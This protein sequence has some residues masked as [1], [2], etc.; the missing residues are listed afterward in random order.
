M[1]DGS[2][3]Q[4][5]W[6][7]DVA[8]NASAWLTALVICAWLLHPALSY[9][10]G[11]E[12]LLSLVGSAAAGLV[13]RVEGI[14][15]SLISAAVCVLLWW[16]SQRA[17]RV[18]SKRGTEACAVALVCVCGLFRLVG[19]SA[20]ES[21]GIGIVESLCWL[22]LAVDL[23]P[24]VLPPRDDG[25]SRRF[26]LFWTCALLCCSLM[27]IA[28]PAVF[29][30]TEALLPFLVFTGGLSVWPPSGNRGSCSNLDGMRRM[31]PVSDRMVLVF[32]RLFAIALCAECLAYGR[33]LSRAGELLWADHL[34]LGPASGIVACSAGV[35]VALYAFAWRSLWPVGLTAVAVGALGC[36]IVGPQGAMAIPLLLILVEYCASVVAMART[37]KDAPGV[38]VDAPA[39]IALFATAFWLAHALAVATPAPG[40]L[41][42][43]ELAVSCLTAS[44]FLPLPGVVADN[45]CRRSTSRSEEEILA[46]R[47]ELRLRFGLTEREALAAVGAVRGM[48]T[49]ELARDAC[50][51][52]STMGTYCARAYRK[53]AVSSREEASRLVRETLSCA[54]IT[55]A[56]Q[57]IEA[58]ARGNSLRLP[59]RTLS[60]LLASSAVSLLVCP[61][62]GD[63]G[64][65]VMMFQRYM[66]L[67]VCGLLI[68]GALVQCRSHRR[69]EDCSHTK[70]LGGIPPISWRLRPAVALGLMAGGAGIG[71]LH[72][73][74]AGSGMLYTGD[75][76]AAF[77]SVAYLFIGLCAIYLLFCYAPALKELAAKA[78][79][80]PMS[81]MGRV[82]AFTGV[83][84][85]LGFVMAEPLFWNRAPTQLLLL[86]GFGLALTGVGLASL[87]VVLR[88]FDKRVEKALV[89]PER[90]AEALAA[91]GLSRA[92]RPVAQSVMEGL[93][94]P[95]IADALVLSKSTVRT[96]LR[97]IYQKLDVHSRSACV[98]RI[99]DACRVAPRWC[100]P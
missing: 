67:V 42:V 17:R 83:G 97:H 27:F 20:L 47:K 76:R 28:V 70:A 9:L 48:T 51:S 52:R 58:H 85:I 55:L 39:F 35:A 8:R 66:P 7:C 86:G 30:L 6:L 91:L 18:V 64:C 15:T 93:S 87:Y 96:H 59:G 88:T 71:S 50:V 57:R 40:A 46:A 53:M 95:M 25:F 29:C 1:R 34:F 12:A 11:R 45:L 82:L 61:W 84:Y 32:C 2:Y 19:A 77:A 79:V 22:P 73:G 75:A 13:I 69:P 33:V 63:R 36:L 38:R 4:A 100:R 65:A 23:L 21:Y 43:L 72:Q 94:V 62:M 54:G 56:G 26:L 80:R 90:L 14:E 16:C 68:A 78:G 5:A 37:G 74:F 44:P 60:A 92:E 81:M 24:R 3:R 99:R 98:E 41:V 89:G 10:V 31:L 49:S